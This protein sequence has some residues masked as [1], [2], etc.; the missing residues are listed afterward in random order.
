M[1]TS[2]AVSVDVLEFV[3]GMGTSRVRVA[4][5]DIDGVLR[6]KF[7]HTEKF[8]SAQEE[9]FG[10]CNV[11]FGWDSQ[12]VCYDHVDYTGWHTG[13]PDALAKVDLS[14]LRRVPWDE[15]LPFF[16]VDFVDGD[17]RPL[18]VCPRQVLK[19]V[20][21]RAEAMGFRALFGS[22]FEFFNFQETP[23]SLAEKSYCGLDSLTPGMFGYSILRSSLNGD[24][25]RALMEEL[26]AF[27]VPVEGLHTE[28][29]PGVYEAAIAYTDP[30]EAADRG[31]LFKTGVKE[32]AYRF[33][34]MPTFMAKWN[35]RLP[36]SSGHLH[37]SLVDGSGKNVFYD[38]KGRGRMSALF[39]SYLAGQLLG[40]THLLPFYAPTVN[41]YKRLVKGLWAP[42]HVTWGIDNRTPALRVIPGTAKST[43]LETRVS[44]ADI[45]P[46]LAMAAALASGL[47]GIEKGLALKD[48]PV[49]GNAY[50]VKDAQSLPGTLLEAT[51]GMERS[52]MA[53]ELFGDVFIDHFAATR[54]WEW[55]QYQR[56]V[57]SWELERY[58]EII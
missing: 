6:G 22:E 38:E 19:K 37:Q 14:T 23:Q 42:T 51:R 16:L 2:T 12:D 52:E 15:G 40:L 3:R 58:F 34:I 46:Y 18:D 4:A 25:M 56:A 44:G 49:V 26:I 54:H 36:G 11:V 17:G 30:V 39:E 5:T 32:I 57:T 41:S 10:F 45:N 35:H 47:Y 8:L 1:A 13:Y 50:D 28:T 33:G 43:R 27:D 31:V 20:V 48:S 29:G 55:E 53:R 21:G 24:Y 9:G 7:M